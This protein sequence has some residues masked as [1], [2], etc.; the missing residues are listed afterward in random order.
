M[1]K[2]APHKWSVKKVIASLINVL[3][4]NAVHIKVVVMAFAL[5]SAL[6]NNAHK[7]NVAKQQIQNIPKAS[8]LPMPVQ[9]SNALNI[10][11]VSKAHVSMT[12]ASIQKYVVNTNYAIQKQGFALIIPANGLIAPLIPSALKANVKKAT[13]KQKIVPQ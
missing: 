2:L 10:M 7:V 9:V 3:L 11:F 8:V 13:P 6:T 4:H 12:D 1:N 5:I